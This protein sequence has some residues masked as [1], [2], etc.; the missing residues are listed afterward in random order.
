[1][2][3]YRSLPDLADFRPELKSLICKIH[4]VTRRFFQN[5]RESKQCRT[6]R[7]LS[8]A[9]GSFS[10]G[11]TKV[12]RRT[13]SRH[14]VKQHKSEPL[15]LVLRYSELRRLHIIPP[16][17]FLSRLKPPKQCLTS[18][19]HSK[20]QAYDIHLWALTTRHRQDSLECWSQESTKR[21]RS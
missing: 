18:A 13:Y 3:F 14:S 7:F 5:E 1:M 2:A 10:R 4:Q 8:G 9:S 15:Q 20:N 19:P 21:R 12:S 17:P 6:L 16:I 11:S